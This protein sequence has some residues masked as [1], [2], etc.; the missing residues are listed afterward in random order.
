M[1]GKSEGNDMGLANKDA[2]YSPACNIHRSPYGGRNSG[3]QSEDPYLSGKVVCNIIKGLGAYGKT[4][5]MKHFICNDQDFNRMGLYTWMNEQALREIYLRTFEEGV[6]YGDSTGIMTSFNR[7]GCI[8][9]GGNEALMTGVLRYEWG[10]KG[11]IITDMTENE[12]NMDSAANLRAGG[13]LNLGGD[14]DPV[15][16]LSTSSTGRVQRRMRQAIKEYI[17]A[18]IHASWKNVTYNQSADPS[19]AVVATEPKQSWQWWRPTLISVDILIYGAIAIGFFVI[20]RQL[21][22]PHKEKQVNKEE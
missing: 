3:Y 2:L 1:F 21:I 19:E 9:A 17:Y 22:V 14:S 6:K 10:F 20:I 18:Y 5:F 13:N 12:D 15:V 11:C 8:W 7:L 4:T 16:T